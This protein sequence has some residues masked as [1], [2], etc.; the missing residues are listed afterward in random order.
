MDLKNTGKQHLANSLGELFTTFYGMTHT[1][2]NRLIARALA[3]KGYNVADVELN[4]LDN[5]ATKI[6]QQNLYLRQPYVELG[7]GLLEKKLKTL[8]FE[9][10]AAICEE[11]ERIKEAA[12]SGQIESNIKELNAPNHISNPAELAGLINRAVKKAKDS[13]RKFAPFIYLEGEKFQKLREHLTKLGIEWVMQ[14]T[15]D[16][17]I[18]YQQILAQPQKYLPFIISFVP[19]QFQSARTAIGF[20]KGYL[21]NISPNMVRDSFAEASYHALI[22][23]RKDEAGEEVKDAA[24]IFMRMTDSAERISMLTQSFIKAMVQV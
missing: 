4:D 23:S 11:A 3:E 6:F 17:H 9:G 10:S 21:D 16:Q 12:V 19:E 2:G 13:R 7:K 22:D 15:G 18:S 24:G 20:A 1:V 8:Q 14:G 5:P